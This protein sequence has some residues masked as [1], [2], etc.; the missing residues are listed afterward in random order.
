M[1]SVNVLI[2]GAGVIG[3][4]YGAHLMRAG[5]RVT[6]LVREKYREYFE[7][8]GITIYCEGAIIP[9]SCSEN[10]EIKNGNYVTKIPDLSDFD[11]IFVTTRA[12][13]RHEVAEQLQKCDVSD[14]KKT[15]LVICFPFWSKSNMDFA[16][17]FAACHYVLPGI[18]G[19]YRNDVKEE[20][21]HPHVYRGITHISPLFNA[22]WDDSNQL[23]LILSCCQLPARVKFNLTTIMDIIMA[24]SFPFFAAISTRGYKTEAL[25]DR[26]LTSIAVKAQKNCLRILQAGGV[27]VGIVGKVFLAIPSPVQ[28]FVLSFSPQFLKGF[29]KEMLEV[30]FKKVHNQTVFLLREL[31]SFPFAQKVKRDSLERLLTVVD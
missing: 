13:Q 25:T 18:S 7:K 3:Q 31:L 24:I 15:Q 20:P 23:R 1:K 29:V 30:H 27:P 16:K 2:M 5:H 10:I 28:T 11:Y 19:V 9:Y 22:S 26:V 14:N 12:D 17:K 21:R 6:F 8:K 4:V